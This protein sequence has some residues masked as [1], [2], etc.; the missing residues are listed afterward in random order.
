MLG[1]P[2]L[3]RPDL[4]SELT[5]PLSD[6]SKLVALAGDLNTRDPDRPVV[7]AKTREFLRND[8]PSYK[9]SRVDDI[10]CRSGEDTG[11]AFR[12]ALCGAC[13]ASWFSKNMVFVGQITLASRR[14][15]SQLEPLRP[16]AGPIF[17]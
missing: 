17:H 14:P 1:I 6:T 16:S 8:C 9:V 7:A 10:L 13:T 15:L 3:R 5:N 2:S 12:G 11:E 4:P